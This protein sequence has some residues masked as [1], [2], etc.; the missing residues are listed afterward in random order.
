MCWS[1][2]FDQLK[3]YIYKRCSCLA[4]FGSVELG[5]KRKTTN[6]AKRDKKQNHHLASIF[7]QQNK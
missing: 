2:F 5:R 4:L 3:K 1:F 6:N 7:G